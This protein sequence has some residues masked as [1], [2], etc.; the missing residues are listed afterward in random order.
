MYT[1]KDLINYWCK[2]LIDKLKYIVG[3]I[4]KCNIIYVINDEFPD[5]VK[6]FITSDEAFIVA[7]EFFYYGLVSQLRSKARNE[8]EFPK[9]IN[10]LNAEEMISDYLCDTILKT[11]NSNNNN[12][13]KIFVICNLQKDPTC[14]R[15]I[16]N[17]TNKTSSQNHHFHKIFTD[18]KKY[19]IKWIETS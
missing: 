5:D 13:L 14:I 18:F 12:P 11:S 16:F 1:M 6:Q 3:K 17:S 4:L 15:L 7:C 9:E 19:V 10:L 2:S 8:F